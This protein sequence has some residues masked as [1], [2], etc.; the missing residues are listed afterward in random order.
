[1]TPEQK[2]DEIIAG[3]EKTSRLARPFLIIGL[4]VIIVSLVA[5]AFY[6]NHR[7]A[8]A[9]E[10]AARWRAKAGELAVTLQQTRQALTNRNIGQANELL[11]RAQLQTGQLSTLAAASSPDRRP[12]SVEQTG[13]VTVGP[14]LRGTPDRRPKSA[15]QIGTVTV[16]PGLKIKPATEGWQEPQ[17]GDGRV[18]DVRT[19]RLDENQVATVT[20][21]TLVNDYGPDSRSFMAVTI[22]GTLIENVAAGTTTLT[23][24]YPVSGR[25]MHKIVVLCRNFHATAVSCSISV[26]VSAPSSG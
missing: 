26:N 15:V 1:M 21:T 22:D 10:Q 25:G 20:A 16:G 2:T 14:G 5:S 18:S 6:L 23:R 19:F 7:R 9:Q 24:S 17:Q 12:K 11:L 13:T 3:I 8:E 4:L